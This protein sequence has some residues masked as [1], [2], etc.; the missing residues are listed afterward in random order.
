[1]TRCCNQNIRLPSDCGKVFCFT[2]A[3]RDSCVRGS[4]QGGKGLTPADITVPANVEMRSK[5][6]TVCVQ[7][8]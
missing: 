6:D 4:E 7:V 5:T 1:M 2:M 8:V 3:E